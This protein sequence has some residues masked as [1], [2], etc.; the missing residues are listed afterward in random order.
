MPL[1]FKR[2]LTKGI[3]QLSF[4]SKSVD[5]RLNHINSLIRIFDGIVE[6]HEVCSGGIIDTVRLKAEMHELDT[7]C[8]Y[9]LLS[10]RLYGIHV[11]F[12]RYA[13]IGY[14]GWLRAIFESHVLTFAGIRI[15]LTTAGWPNTDLL[16]WDTL[17]RSNYINKGACGTG[18]DPMKMDG[19]TGHDQL[20]AR[21]I[22]IKDTVA[23]SLDLIGV[24]L[25]IP[26]DVRTYLIAELLGSTA[27]D[28]SR[29]IILRKRILGLLYYTGLTV[30]E[31]TMTTM[32]EATVKLAKDL[33]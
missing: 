22:T 15:E 25:E 11:A 32:V 30:S 12:T 13:P 5:F 21:T 17:Y 16:I 31:E 2:K 20:T 7:V 8:L 33:R 4:K 1:N 18:I 26:D 28:L 19:V 24:N 3:E 6:R 10:E 23:A 29:P 14:R 9:P 27:V